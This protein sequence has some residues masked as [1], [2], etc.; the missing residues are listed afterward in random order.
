MNNEELD[1][2]E[3]EYSQ[4]A[5]EVAKL[6]TQEA[7]LVPYASKSQAPYKMNTLIPRNMAFE[8]QKSLNR[9][10]KDKGNID[11]YVRNLPSIL[12]KPECVEML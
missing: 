3:A 10:V 12:C 1:I 11:N 8:V 6:A 4:N 5:D 2:K 7:A 9:I